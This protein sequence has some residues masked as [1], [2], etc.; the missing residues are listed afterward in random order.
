MPCVPAVNPVS[1][2]RLAPA[3]ATTTVTTAARFDR[4]CTLLAQAGLQAAVAELAFMA[5]RRCAGVFVLHEGRCLALAC[6]DQQRPGVARV[7]DVGLAGRVHCFVK[8]HQAALHKAVPAHGQPELPASVSVPII[9]AEG[10]LLGTLACFD[11]EPQSRAAV[12]LELL[13]QVAAE[14]AR[15]EAVLRAPTRP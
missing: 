5:R 4:F 13:L 2:A 7:A 8:V 9:T 14:L 3:D 11:L 10:H 15:N 1:A 6:H 12:D